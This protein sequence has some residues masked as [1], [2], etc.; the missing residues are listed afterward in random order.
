M[1][2]RFLADTTTDE[3]ISLDGRINMQED[4]YINYRF[5][6]V[7]NASPQYILLCR[8][9]ANNDINGTIRIDRTSGNYQA[10]SLD[11]I[12]TSGSSQMF[13]G[14]LATL[15]VIQNSE[16]YRLISCTYNSANYIAIKYTGNTYPETSGGYFTGR[17]KLSAGTPFQVVTSGV[18]NEAS[19]GG[20]SESYNEVDNFVISGDLTVGGGD[21]VLS[22]TGRIQGVDTVSASTDAANKNYVDTQVAGVP[23]GTVQSVTGTGNVNGI[24]LTD[25]GSTT[26]PTLTLGGTLSISNDD[27][28]GADLSVANGGTGASTAAAARTNLGIVN[29]T[30]TPAILSDGSTPSL[31]TGITAAEVRSLI[32]AG[33]SSTTGTV[34]SVATGA[35]LTGGTITTSGTVAVDYAGTDNF[36]LAAGAGSGTPAG[37][38]HIPLSDGSNNVDYYNVSELPFSDN[39][40]TV[41][42]VAISGGTGISVSGSPITSSGTITITNDSPNVPETFTEWVVR[43]DDDDDKTLSG[44]TN[45]YL[46]FVAATGTLGTNLSGTGT[47][48]DPYV[49][50]ITSPDSDSG[51]TV[52]SVSGAGSVNGLTLTGTVTTSGDLTLGGTLAISN[53][54]WSGADLAIANGGTGAST[55]AAAI[56]NLGATTV[57]G[58]LFTLTNPSA[59]RF[60]RINAN[61]TVS[62][63]TASDFRTAIGAGTS[64]TTGTVTSVGTTAPITGGTITGSGT[65]GISN[66]TGT[67][68]GAAA[69]DAGV[70]ISVSDSNG[71]YTIANAG[72]IGWTQSADTGTSVSVANGGTV[73]LEGGNNISTTISAGVGTATVTFDMDTGGAGAGTYGSTSNSTKIDEITLD[74][75][76]RVTAVTT[77]ATGS[78]SMSSWTIA[79]DS[80][81]NAISNGNTVTIAGGTNITTAESGGT[82]TITNG[83]TNN[84]QLINGAGY[85][86]NAGNTI[87][88]GATVNRVP[89]FSGSVNLANSSIFDNG[90]NAQAT[91]DFAIEGR[92]LWFGAQFSGGGGQ[93]VMSTSGLSSTLLVGDTE[94]NDDIQLIKFITVGKN[95]MSVDDDLVTITASEF[96]I[97]SSTIVTL[98][99]D[100]QI[101]YSHSGSTTG[102]ANGNVISL[103][104][105]SVTAGLVYCLNT[106]TTWSAVANTSSNSKKMLGVATGTSS[107]SGM[108]LQ[109]VFTKA[110]HGFSIGAPLYISSSAGSLTTTVPSATNSYARVVGYAVDTNNIYFCPDNTWVQN[111]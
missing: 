11:V 87:T 57:G 60:I 76:G 44:S 72:M 9:A 23:Q 33:T 73:D 98:G 15:Q 14:C 82:V 31:N 109:G 90:T 78:G 80:G 104:S 88:S 107:N 77:G 69:I 32:G 50:T 43:D 38:W 46:K 40:G 95:Q 108:L 45:K 17:A 79:G 51:G 53:D 16:D 67:T 26:T 97:G 8:N 74:A 61:N 65:I 70:G 59:I 3:N 39:A 66:A 34:T 41:T 27:W 56:T 101:K 18:T 91:G 58:N 94:E 10:V 1:A 5:D 71:V 62:A 6:M 7:D 37:T 100:S 2:I 12:V 35:G 85:T 83:I 55:A 21:I 63:L 111:N 29:D 86:T 42:S 81:S 99:T 54:D 93:R 47:S 89:R 92:D 75:Y 96:S 102:L 64:S 110:S 24:T 20:N 36:I 19:F 30:G 106:N 22:G 25:D 49:M 103:G 52:T 68:V 4:H 84:N 13:G 28:S 105:S 48:A